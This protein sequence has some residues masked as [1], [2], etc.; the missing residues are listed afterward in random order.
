MTKI[1]SNNDFISALHS[2]EQNRDFK[3]LGL[4]IGTKK[5]GI[6]VYNSVTRIALPLRTIKYSGG[7]ESGVSAVFSVVES[8][9]VDGLIIGL[10]VLWDGT[11]GSSAEFVKSFTNDL[12]KHLERV[13]LDV[14][15]T[16]Y[17]ERFT[18]AMANRMLK[19][20]K[21]KRKKRESVDDEFAAVLLLEGFLK[22]L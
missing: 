16:L 18:T 11:H 3:L 1:L 5:V 10:P 22:K 4:D 6:S 8:E 9:K 2:F 20:T 7:R 12:N 17:D 13:E 19:E 15:I 21:L 14:I